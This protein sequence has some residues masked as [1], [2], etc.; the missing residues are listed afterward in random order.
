M[1]SPTPEGAAR[2]EEAAREIL[3]RDARMPDY[4]KRSEMAWVKRGLDN[5]NYY[6]EHAPG[7][8]RAYLDALEA[9]EDLLKE[10]TGYYFHA[11]DPE[12]EKVNRLRRMVG[13]REQL[14]KEAEAELQWKEAEEGPST[15]GSNA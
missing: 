5:R 7:V 2:P 3:R 13:W 14:H 12:L 1:T 15:E 4:P 6:V 11:D 10:L 8:T 9:I